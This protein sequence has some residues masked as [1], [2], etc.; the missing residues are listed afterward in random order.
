MIGRWAMRDVAYWQ[1]NNR[2]VIVIGSHDS[3]AEYIRGNLPKLSRDQGLGPFAQGLRGSFHIIASIDGDTVAQGSVTGSRRLFYNSDGVVAVASDRA[4]SLAQVA[5]SE[6]NIPALASR[7]LYPSAPHPVESMSMWRGIVSVAEDSTLTLQRSGKVSLR[8][9]WAPPDPVL[10]LDTGAERLK[11][12][13]SAS[14]K[15][16]IDGRNVISADLSG[17]LDSTPICFLAAKSSAK[18]LAFTSSGRSSQDDDMY[19]ADLAA[20][21]LPEIKRVIVSPDDLPAPFESIVNSA[22]LALDEP[23][24][25]IVNWRRLVSTAERLAA[26]GSQLHFTG[27]GGDEVLIGPESYVFEMLRRH[28]IRGFRR[29]RQHRAMR[30]WRWGDLLARSVDFRDYPTWLGEFGNH[31]NSGMANRRSPPSI[32]GTPDIHLPP[33]CTIEARSD[34]QRLFH[35]VAATALPLARNRSQ[36]AA[37]DAARGSGRA[38]RLLDQ[39]MRT[40]GLP[41]SAPLLD[42]RVVEC[43]LAVRDDEKSTPWR[44]KP[45][46]VSAMRGSVPDEVLER[47]TKP[48]FTIDAHQARRT[49][50]D[51]LLSLC[52]GSRLAKLGL[53]NEKLLRDA[54]LGAGT[55][56]PQV[57]LWRTLCCEVWLRSIERRHWFRIH[58]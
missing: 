48:D 15:T 35:S 44:Y 11:E 29:L 23:F 13:L 24:L 42:D 52:E 7:L 1:E 54:C 46:I 25:G 10:S 2:A 36:H 5:R 39:M 45:L 56:V 33:W 17:G 26:L 51:Q 49:H 20:A 9:W 27:H 4:D 55:P 21:H 8:K 3:S 47:S 53:V 38:S 34:V 12:E 57:A 37:I 16:H 14:V 18:L 41:M 50:A 28:P 30:R 43:C 32:W 6:I 58:A 19:W 31:I 22:E 40:V